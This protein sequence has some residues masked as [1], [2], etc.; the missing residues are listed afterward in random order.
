[1]QLTNPRKLSFLSLFYSSGRCFFFQFPS[2][3]F[4]PLALSGRTAISRHIPV[5]RNLAHQV[6][7]PPIERLPLRLWPTSCPHKLLVPATVPLFDQWIDDPRL[8]M[9]RHPEKSSFF[10][11]VT[12]YPPPSLPRTFGIFPFFC[13][14]YGGFSNFQFRPDLSLF[15]GSFSPCVKIRTLIGPLFSVFRATRRPRLFPDTSF[16]VS[17]LCGSLLA[18]HRRNAN[19]SFPLCRDF[20]DPGLDAFGC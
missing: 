11:P 4:S 3:V 13:L 20:M 7:V 10:S 8:S 1:V 2:P 18:S 19:V 15:T 14:H 6:V 5:P 16:P 9:L 17:L 12:A